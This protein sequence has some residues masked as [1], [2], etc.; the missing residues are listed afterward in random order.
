MLAQ[1]AHIRVT[2]LPA[3]H[4]Q[5]EQPCMNTYNWRMRRRPSVARL[6]FT[7]VMVLAVLVGLREAPAAAGM[8]KMD[9][10]TAGH[11]APPTREPC[12]EDSSGC[13]VGNRCAVGCVA[14]VPFHAVAASLPA[15]AAEGGY[16][17]DGGMAI[18]SRSLK[19]DPYPPRSRV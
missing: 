8:A 13:I 1:T 10:A 16:R 7:L 4:G 12:S 18:V 15:A 19:P 2:L 6:A 3:A 9:C 17:Q 11:K 5:I 14:Q